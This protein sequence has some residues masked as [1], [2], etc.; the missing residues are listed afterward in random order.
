MIYDIITWLVSVGIGIALLFIFEASDKRW[1][2]REI[3]FFVK[4]F[5]GMLS[6]PFLIYALPGMQLL[7]TKSRTT[8]YDRYFYILFPH[9]FIRT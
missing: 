1:Q 6:F 9:I 5:Y 7:L 8:A 4:L 3:F 2:M